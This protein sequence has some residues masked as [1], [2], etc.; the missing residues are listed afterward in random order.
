MEATVDPQS[1][2]PDWMP[3]TPKTGSLFHADS[4]EARAVT[5][6]LCRQP[7]VRFR[8][9]NLARGFLAWSRVA[10]ALS[11]TSPGAGV[12]VNLTSVFLICSDAACAD[13]IRMMI[14]PCLG[15][16]QTR[17][18]Y[19]RSG[20]WCTLHSGGGWFAPVVTGQPS[21]WCRSSFDGAPTHRRTCCAGMR[22]AQS[23]DDVG[24]ACSI[25]AGVTR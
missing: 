4:H 22:G 6:L 24:R 15:R 18:R 11:A 14:R 21:R 10:P 1:R 2:G 13:V 19:R 3:I 7:D 9:W 20:N 5:F 12:P 8:D 25:Q 16:G 17:R 23:A